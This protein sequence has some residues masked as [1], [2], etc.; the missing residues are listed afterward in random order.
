MLKRFFNIADSGG[1]NGQADASGHIALASAL[2]LAGI[3]IVSPGIK[4]ALV[5]FLNKQFD[6]GLSPDTPWYVGLLLI[7]LG[8][9]SI[10]VVQALVGE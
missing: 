3:A 9:A 1:V 5:S 7:G 2:V 4:D 8:V 10:A 6:L